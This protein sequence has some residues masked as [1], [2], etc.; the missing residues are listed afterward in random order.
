M[1]Y[2]LITWIR[3]INVISFIGA[4]ILLINTVK[5]SSPELQI[6]Y[7]FLTFTLG[8]TFLKDI[9]EIWQERQIYNKRNVDRKRNK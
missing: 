7:A 5:G 6:T 8:L 3:I 2:S 4:L 9:Y 1:S